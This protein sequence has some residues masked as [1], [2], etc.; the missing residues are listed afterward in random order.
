MKLNLF[1]RAKIFYMRRTTIFKQLILNVVIPAVLALLVLGFFNYTQTKY[2]LKESISTKNKLISEEILHIIEFQDVALNILEESLNKVMKEYS[3]MLV[4]KYFKN[5]KNIEY[6]DLDKVRKEIGMD[7]ER[8]DIYVINREGI[9]VNTTF[10]NDLGLPFFSFGE[11][12]KNMLLGIFEKGEFVSE[13]FA[14]E[15]HTKRLKKYTYQ[16]TLDGKFIIEIGVYSKKA[17]EVIDYIKN[18]I[19]KL[20]VEADLFLSKDKPFSLNRD[21]LL[22]DTEKK[23]VIERF[24]KEDSASF[25]YRIKNKRLTYDYM[26]MQRSNTDLY[27]GAVIRIIS[28]RTAETLLLRKELI[29]FVL[30]FSLTLL[31]VITLLYRKT[32]VITTPIKKLVDKVNRITNGHFNERAEV[33]GNNEIATLSQKFNNMIEELESYYNELEQKVKDRT[34][35]VVRQKEEIE[36]KNKHITDSIRY[37]KRIQNAIL[38]PSDY[39]KQTLPNSFIFYRPKDIVSGDFFWV[40]KKNNLSFYATVDCTGHGVPGAFMSIVGFNQLNYAIDVRKARTANEILDSLNEGVVETLRE[41]SPDSVSSVKDGMDITLCVIDYKNMKLQ[42]AGANNPLVLIRNNEI[43]Q[44]KA[45]KFAIGGNFGN[46]LPKFTNNEIDLQSGD[47]IY[48]FSDGYADQFGGN[49]G[50]K[51]MV[52]RFRELLL[53]IH[54]DPIEDQASLLENIL[55]EWRGREEQVDDILVIGVKIE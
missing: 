10:K 33:I 20:S 46:E 36:I 50:R 16:P 38:P 17:D 9:V 28:D 29:K 15:D 2:N 7:M 40:T 34:A 55:D 47:V 27:K 6:V 35:E 52:K 8:E 37:A 3:G 14:I 30:V 18:T 51:F 53:S 24:N 41:K 11:D 26:Y 39:V 32:R 13:R 21:L 5:T 12:H 4:N 42:F 1:R 49:D 19:N 25:S 48:T 31:V 44:Y 43:I 23:I 54:K 45:D 22:S